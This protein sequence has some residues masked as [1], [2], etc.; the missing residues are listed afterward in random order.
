MTLEY[1][2]FW[3]QSIEKFADTLHTYQAI[4]VTGLSYRMFPGKMI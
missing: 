2:F 1:C 3:K 4:I